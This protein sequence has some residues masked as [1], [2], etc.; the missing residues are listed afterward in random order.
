MAA[1]GDD[2]RTG[3]SAIERGQNGFG[4]S[5]EVRKVP[6]GGLF[7]SPDVGRLPNILGTEACKTE[8][9]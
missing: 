2:K 7:W 5:G 3:D 6:I 9:A 8:Y 4:S 1:L